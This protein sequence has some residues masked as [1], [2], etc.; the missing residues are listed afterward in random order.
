ME[1]LSFIN[2]L[3]FISL[4]FSAIVTKFMSLACRSISFCGGIIIVVLN[5]RGR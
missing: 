1:S 4:S 5:L 2:R 3:K